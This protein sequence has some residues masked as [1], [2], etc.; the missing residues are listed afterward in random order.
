V[1]DSRVGPRRFARGTIGRLEI[2]T[3]VVTAPMVVALVLRHR[4]WW[5]PLVVLA[6]L[7][8]FLDRPLAIDD[9]LFVKAAEQILQDPLRPLHGIIDWYGNGPRYLWGI[10]KNPPGLSY[11]LAAARGLGG[12]GEVVLHAA[13]LP[14]AIAAALAGVRLARRFAGGSPWAAAIWLASP[15]F[16]V[17]ASTLMPDVPAL[18]LTLWGAVLYVEGVDGDAPARRRLAALVAG[19]AVVLKY[20]AVVNVAVLGLYALLG[21]SIESPGDRSIRPRGLGGRGRH[22][23]RDVL[24]LWP[25]ALPLAGWTVLGLVTTGRVHFIDSLVVV[26]GPLA[27][28]PGWFSE[29]GIAMPVFV[30]G[31]G[32]FPAVLAVAA[33]RARGACWAL[34]LGALVGVVAGLAT[35][36]I[37]P[38]RP[39]HV[40]VA[41]GALAALGASALLLACLDAVRGARADR[42]D[43]AFLA[44]WTIANVLFAWFWSWTIAARFI[45]PAMPPLALLLARSLGLG[46]PSSSMPAAPDR[47][48]HGANDRGRAERLL[49]ATTL[50]SL[51]LAT[52]VL[53]ADTVPTAFLR[54][55][56]PQLAAEAMAE[57][58]RPYFVGAWG[59]HYYAERAGMQRL[60]GR[61]P[62]SRPG[63]L[64]IAPYYVANN[65][66]PPALVGHIVLVKEIAAAVPPLHLHTM[67]AWVGAGFYSTVAG[68]LPFGLGNRPAEGVRVWRQTE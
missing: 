7:L 62:Q 27:S 21:S 26:G 2:P 31:A 46:R 3:R 68:P 36:S 6:P 37:W 47:S 52:V 49:A 14:F 41:A 20:T 19:A 64:V 9:T 60:N 61:A 58:R 44:A 48:P 22:R 15:A 33:W 24:D 50:A 13:L 65:A 38:R 34:A 35:E 66:M 54:G 40:A 23:T 16:L 56:I 5:I 43:S 12:S 25:A 32:V 30:A 51:T 8:A 29:R 11:W 45:L 17:S 10:A 63:D 57:G 1:C 39:G 28:H 53:W 18:A 67:N 42:A 55:V 4:G 59:F